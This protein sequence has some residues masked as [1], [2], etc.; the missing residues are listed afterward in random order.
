MVID[1]MDI[2]DEKEIVHIRSGVYSVHPFEREPTN[3]TPPWGS[4]QQMY[5]FDTALLHAG[6][7]RFPR[8]DDKRKRRG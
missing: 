3:E 7:K 2:P 5:C 8:D 4:P 6:Q 1:E